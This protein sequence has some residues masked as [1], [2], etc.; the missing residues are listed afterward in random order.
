MPR[1]GRIPAWIRVGIVTA[2]MRR[3]VTLRHEGYQTVSLGTGLSPGLTI[4]FAGQRRFP[5]FVG[6]R[7]IPLL[8]LHSGTQRARLAVTP[9]HR[10]HSLDV[11][12]CEVR[13]APIGPGLWPGPC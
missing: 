5:L 1:T 6:D 8:I 4:M 11:Q 13:R 2:S 9:E 10:Q 12:R 7:H 3:P